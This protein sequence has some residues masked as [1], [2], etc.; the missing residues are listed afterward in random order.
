MTC[1]RR[2]NHYK[3]DRTPE[4]AGL[5]LLAVP[6]APNLYEYFYLENKHVLQDQ[7]EFLRTRFK[8][9]LVT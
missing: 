1:C 5:E 9:V 6:F 8:N 4:E 3:N 7:M 2:C